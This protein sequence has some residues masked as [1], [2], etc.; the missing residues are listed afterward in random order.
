MS[1]YV[2]IKSFSNGLKII[3]D[4]SCS[5]ADIKEE[6]RLKFVDSSK[7]FKGTKVAVTFEGRKIDTAEELILVRTMEEAASMTVLYVIGMDDTT[8]E[9]Y[10]K[11]MSTKMEHI[12]DSNSYGKFYPGSL[13]KGN[14]LKSDSGIVIIGD[15]EP[16]ATV[17]SKGSIVILGGLYGSAIILVEEDDDPMGL[18]VSCNDLSPEKLCIGDYTYFSKDKAK[19]VVKPKMVP[20]IAFVSNNQVCVDCISSK[21]LTSISELTEQ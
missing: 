12:S 15:V 13:K 1:S 6:L 3:L 14:V 16:G 18:F 20:K 8:Q 21:T 5:F 19:W 11:A 10:A 9:K 2:T 7:F 17:Y 4:D